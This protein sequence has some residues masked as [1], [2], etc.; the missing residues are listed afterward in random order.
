MIELMQV[1]SCSVVRGKAQG[2]LFRDLSLS[3]RAGRRYLISGPSGSG[4]TTLALVLAGLLKPTSG[5]V[6]RMKPL[7]Q[8][9]APIRMVFQDPFASMN[10]LWKV[11]DWLEDNS[12]SVNSLERLLAL[13]KDF[14]LSR[15]L[16]DSYPLELSGGECQ[17]FNLVCALAGEPL[18]LILDEAT[19]MVDAAT[20]RLM[21]QLIDRQCAELGTAIINIEHRIADV[22]GEGISIRDEADC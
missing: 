6:V 11:G 13:C 19:S 18:L 20:R 22:A 14:D 9:A 15:A 10:P 21:R 17:R 5:R 16:L 12:P 3:V 8:R 2:P 4:K 7:Q 1:H